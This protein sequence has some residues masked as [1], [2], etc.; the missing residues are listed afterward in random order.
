MLASQMQINS[1]DH[2]ILY[3]ETMAA[4]RTQPYVIVPFILV[5]SSS[6]AEKHLTGGNGT[7]T[8]ILPRTLE[9]V[10]LN[11]D[12]DYNSYEE[13]TWLPTKPSLPPNLGKPQRCDYDRCRDQERPCV[14]LSAASGCQCPGLSGPQEV[15]EAPYLKEVSQQGSDAVV[16]WCAPASTVSHYQI[17]VKDR[18]PLVFM[19]LSRM[20]V[21]KDLEAGATVCVE[22]VNAA[23]V[24]SPVQYSCMTYEPESDGSLALKAGLIG[25]ALGLLLLLSLVIFLLWRRK[26]CGKS[27]GRSSSHTTDEASL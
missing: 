12:E 5:L 17:V 7:K 4:K 8:L 27:G 2:L 13:D 9:G 20:G 18:E 10:G 24:S 14:E 3:S 22:A 16:K 11:P 6:Y 26:V 23:G 15:P 21:L 25:G 1:I 19:G